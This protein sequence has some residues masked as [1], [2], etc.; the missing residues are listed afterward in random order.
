V[1][2]K[3]PGWILGVL[4]LRKERKRRKEKEGRGR[5]VRGEKGMEKMKGEERGE[6]MGEKGGKELP[7]RHLFLPTSNSEGR[8]KKVVF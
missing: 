8:G 3:L 1:L 5:T 4:L 7:Y 6:A 2:S